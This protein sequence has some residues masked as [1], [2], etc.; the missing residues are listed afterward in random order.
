M[1][2]RPMLAAPT[3]LDAIQ[4][5]CYVSPK[6]DGIRGVLW[7]GKALT[8]SLKE[9]PNKHVAAKYGK[10][11]HHGLDGEFIVG[12]PTA[13]DSYRTTNSALMTRTGT[14]DPVFYV[15][16]DLSYPD[17]PFHRRLDTARK[18]VETLGQGFHLL[19][20]HL[21][22]SVEEL[23]EY[24]ERWLNLGYEG[25]MIRHPMGKYKYGRS[26]ESQGWLLK[27]KR[28]QDS[29]AQ[30]IGMVEML[31]NQNE[32]KI[33]ELGLTERPSHKEHQVPAGTMGA[34]VVKDVHHGWVFEIGTGFTAEDRD[35]FWGNREQLVRDGALVKYQY[36]SVGMKD[37]PRH[38]SYKGLRHRDDMGE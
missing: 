4:F 2:L 22:R 14:P 13:P 9:I 21:I 23:L 6:L 16:D 27:L 33:N 5:P 7:E 18:K 11:E 25:V 19:T 31:S 28:F 17:H 10:T 38:P 37:L 29:E 20:H 30:I 26:T 36:F 1:T 8:R 3:T 34:L 32:A 24:E 12:S 15:F 35:W